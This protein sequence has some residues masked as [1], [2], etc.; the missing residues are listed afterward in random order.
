MSKDIHEIERKFQ[1]LSLEKTGSGY[2]LSLN[3]GDLG[4]RLDIAQLA[5]D[6]QVW[7]DVRRYMP[8]DTGTLISLTNALNAAVRGKV[9]LYPPSSDYGHYQ[10]EG[11][12]YVDPVTGAA[13]FWTEDGWKSR[14]G[15]KKIP[16]GQPLKYTDPNAQAHWGEVAYDNHN[17]QWLE[18]VK[19][20]AGVI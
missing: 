10:Y 16:S 3:F 1:K 2:K 7:A 12:K 5:L 14:R 11:I 13:G 18:V 17:A 20:A 4:A 8:H 15:V 9:Y 6:A 19:R